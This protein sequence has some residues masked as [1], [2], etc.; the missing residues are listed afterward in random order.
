MRLITKLQQ[1]TGHKLALRTLFEHPSVD[2]LAMVLNDYREPQTYRPVLNLRISGDFSPLFCVHPAGGFATVFGE[3]SRALVSPRPV[4]GLQARGL[5]GLEP[6]FTSFSEM[7]D[8]YVKAV[9]DLQPK[10]ILNFIGYSAGGVIAHELACLLQEL[11]REIGIVALVDSVPVTE[12]IVQPIET[13]EGLLLEIAKEY[14]WVQSENIETSELSEVVLNFLAHQNQ[15]PSG[16]PVDWIDR[17]VQETLLS[18]SRLSEHR[19]RKGDFDAIYF[20]AEGER[21]DAE[22]ITKRLAWHHYCREVKYFPIDSTHNRML[23]PNPS[24]KIA[25]VVDRILPK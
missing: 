25:D 18:A 3:F 9:L 8:A 12:S 7:I 19:T 2:A 17:M 10:G 6:P 24:K 4:Y 21:A 11:G 14:G 22:L 5:E 20:S 23:D 13:R 1:S 16:T 15:I